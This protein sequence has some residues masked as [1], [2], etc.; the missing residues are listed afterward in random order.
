MAIEPG[1]V[2]VVR[3]K[4][5]GY[6]AQLGEQAELELEVEPG[7]TVADLLY[8][9]AKRLGPEFRQVLLDRQGNLQGGV[10]VMLNRN[11]ISARKISEVV[12]WDESDLAIMPLVGG[13]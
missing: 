8:L 12:L 13:G 3:V 10:E 11:Q 6:L 4:L 7:S 5:F 1:S 2:F 9:L